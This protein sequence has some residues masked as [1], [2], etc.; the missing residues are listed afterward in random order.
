L[1]RF[2]IGGEDLEVTDSRIMKLKYYIL[3]QEMFYDELKRNMIAYGIEIEK[4]ENET[5]E[6]SSINNVTNDVKKINEIG[7][8]LKENVVLP[9]HLEDV[10]LDILS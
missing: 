7:H 8:I 2:Y 6:S 10:I 5:V 9:V 1:A 4:I 3:E